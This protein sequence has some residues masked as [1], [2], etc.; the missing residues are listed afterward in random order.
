[1]SLWSTVVWHSISED[2]LSYMYCVKRYFVPAL[3]TQLAVSHSN[4]TASKFQVR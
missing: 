2:R 4:H 3:V 1:M